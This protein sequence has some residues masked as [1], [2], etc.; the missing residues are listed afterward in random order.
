MPRTVAVMALDRITGNEQVTS[1]DHEMIMV[2][3]GKGKRIVMRTET[4]RERNV[5]V[6]RRKREAQMDQELDKYGH[7]LR[8]Q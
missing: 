3:L 6:A 8:G 4:S 1:Q 5:Q 2:K 7:E